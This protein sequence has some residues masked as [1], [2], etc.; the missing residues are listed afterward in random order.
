MQNL[1]PATTPEQATPRP[2]VQ[3][4]TANADDAGQRLDNFLIRCLK[5]VPKSHIHSM[6]RSGEVR[7]NKGRVHSDT[8]ITEGDVV[9]IPPVRVSAP[10]VGIIPPKAYPVV[11]EDE[12]VLC[13][14]KPAGVAVHGGSGVAYGVIEQLRVHLQINEFGGKQ[15]ASFIELVH[16]LDRDTSGV[17]MLAKNRKAL[18]TMQESLKQG[19]WKKQYCCVVFGVPAFVQQEVNIPLRKTSNEAGE[20]HVYLAKGVGNGEGEGQ[21]ALTRFRVLRKNAQ[22]A[23]LSAR[24]MTGRTHQIRVHAQSLGFP[25]AGDEKYGDFE[26]NKALRSVGLKRL[27][28]HAQNLSLPHPKT[29]LMLQFEATPPKEYQS[30]AASFLK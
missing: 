24:I 25:L 1:S 23:E 17:L 20:R 27:M 16:R 10:N 2:A 5:G 11:Y 3:L 30:F 19:L 22:G 4:R 15:A 26:R 7:I 18:V 29:G 14:N 13:I 28:L 8:R 6:I 9:R 12:D 21:F